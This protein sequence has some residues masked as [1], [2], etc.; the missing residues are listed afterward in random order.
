MFLVSDF[1][2]V[3]TKKSGD[4]PISFRMYTNNTSSNKEVKLESNMYPFNEDS[5]TYIELEL[6]EKL[7]SEIEKLDKIDEYL[8]YFNL[9]DVIRGGSIEFEVDFKGINHSFRQ[10]N[11]A[12]FRC[13]SEEPYKIYMY[14][15]SDSDT[16]KIVYFTSWRIIFSLEICLLNILIPQPTNL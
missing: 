15:K 4:T 14:S 7:K 3:Q 9:C 8:R 6:K 11:M 10:L 5:Y 1:I 2:Y 16:K 12:D 13:I